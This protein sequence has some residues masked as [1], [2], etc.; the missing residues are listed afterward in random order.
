MIGNSA[1]PTYQAFL[2]LGIAAIISAVLMP[3][4]IRALKFE[5][6]GQQVRADGPKRHLVKQGTPTM[7]G[8]VI[9]VAVTITCLLMAKITIELILVLAAMLAT[10]LLGL[11]DDVTSVT[12]G[13]SLGLTPKA[14]MVGLTLICVL[15]C[16]G[17][18]NFCGVPAEVRFP[19]GFAIDLGVLST[20][21]QVA[22]ATITVPWLFVL[23]TWLLIAGFSNAVNLTDGLDGL[24]GGTSMIAMLIMAA[25]AYICD[26]ANLA[27]FGTACAGGCLG[28]LWFNCYPASIFM[29]DTGSLALGTA[30]ACMGVVTN[31]EISS[32]IIGGL[33]I[34][35]ALSVIIQVVSFHFTHKRVFL[36]APIHHHFEKKGWA[37]TKVVIRFWIVSAAFGALGLAIFFQLGQ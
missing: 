4:W 31:T 26:D 23:F 33:F 27:I 35:E 16:L 32:L 10:G 8:V 9:L 29:G 20:T 7:G 6:I 11:I 1:Y 15:F 19:G 12:H 2:A 36:M 21:F 3:L 28:F 13:R 22:G 25:I 30:F 24:A 34:A 5:G 17:A 37:E 14:K 18:V